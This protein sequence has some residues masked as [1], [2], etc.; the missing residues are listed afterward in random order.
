MQKEWLQSKNHKAI[1]DMIYIH[2]NSENE[3]PIDVL[4][5]NISDN[6]IRNKFTDLILNLDNMEPTKTMVLGCLI[7]LEKRILKKQLS[8]LK[9]SLKSTAESDISNIF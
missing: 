4:T 5:N 9:I 6:N 7:Q 2:L 8:E 1:Y 3:M